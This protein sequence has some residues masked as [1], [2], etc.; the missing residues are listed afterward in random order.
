[1]NAAAVRAGRWSRWLGAVLLLP[2]T[3]I[4]LAFAVPEVVHQY[5]AALKRLAPPPLLRAVLP[6][7]PV[8]ASRHRF[9]P[10]PAYRGAVPVLTYHGINGGTGELDVT[11]RRFAA[12]M[13]MLDAAGFHTISI[14]Q[15]TRWLD[16]RARHLPSRPV[17]VTFDDGRFDSYAGADRVLAR[18]GFRATMFTIARGPSDR[19]NPFYSHWPEVRRMAAS[20]RW[21]VQLHAYAGHV[22]VPYDAAGHTGPFYAYRRYAGGRLES[23]RA[24]RRRVTGDLEAGVA[25]LRR[26]VPGFEPLAFADPYGN[27]GNVRSNDRRIGPFMQRWLG[28]HFGAVFTLRTPHY[29][30]RTDRRDD[31]RRHEIHRD[32]TPAALYRWLRRADPGG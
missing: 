19:H 17:L 13:A 11:Q 22:L 25:E 5:E 29:T 7:P 14:R 1:V 23:Y 4:P 15:Y 32:T 3:L 18:H 27:H 26:Q 8:P 9:R 2:L 28:R 6:A 24:F 21:D 30:R 31:I 20:G 10:V 16:G 12:Q